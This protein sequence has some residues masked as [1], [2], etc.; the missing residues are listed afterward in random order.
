VR[1]RLRIRPGLCG[2]F[3]EQVT[4][5][6]LTDLDQLA[7]P[8]RRTVIAVGARA[9]ARLIELGSHVASTT[10]LPSSTSMLTPLVND[11]LV[12]LEDRQVTRTYDRVLL[13]YNRS[14]GDGGFAPE[15]EQLLPLSPTRMED[16]RTRP[17]PSRAL[18]MVTTDRELVWS[19]LVHEWLSVTVHRALAESLAAENASRLAAMQAAERNIAERL[20]ALH[21]RYHLRRQT[22][23]TNE[24][25]DIVSGVEALTG[26]RR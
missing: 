23:I 4:V 6:A 24:L 9:A 2:S 25:L 18:P 8:A 19:A 21:A 12:Q 16:L 10:E 3:N 26:D 14:R 13:Y 22:A 5:H 20:E 17:W 11:L 1:G 15:R 7:P